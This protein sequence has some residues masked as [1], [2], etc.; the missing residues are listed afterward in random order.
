MDNYME[1]EI[2]KLLEVL[3]EYKRLDIANQ[4]DYQKFYLYSLITHSTA[5]EGSTVTELENQLLFDDG[6]PASGKP[7][8]EQ[9]MN[10]DLKR[11]Y[12]QAM[13]WA[14][15]HKALSVEMLKSLSALVMRNTGSV[16]STLAGE[17]DSSQGDLR[18]VNVT[19]GAGGRSY[20]NFQKV[21]VRLQEFCEVV[22]RREALLQTPNDGE[23]YLLSF[24][25]HCLLVS[26]HPWVDGNG[27]MSR[28]LMNYIQWEFGLVPSKVMQAD[29]AAYMG[30]IVY[31]AACKSKVQRQNHHNQHSPARESSQHS[32]VGNYHIDKSSH[33]PENCAR[34][35]GGNCILSLHL[36]PEKG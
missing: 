23:A 28:L 2:D 27:R 3:A 6:I 11:A 12:E 36:I 15:E 10:L 31:P 13:R 14:R 33:Q 34:R 7:M 21:P 4:I 30:D 1:K 26:I 35:S 5:I 29:K 18:L 22:N 25:A 20:M 8:V 9:L 24:D 32:P 16:Y 17:F 19:A